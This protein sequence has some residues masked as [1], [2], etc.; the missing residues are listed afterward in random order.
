[1]PERERNVSS[2]PSVSASRQCRRKTPR[3]LV[4]VS[5]AVEKAT[6]GDVF[7]RGQA[8]RAP[9]VPGPRSSARTRPVA[10]FEGNTGPV[11]C[12][13]AWARM[14]PGS[15]RRIVSDAEKRHQ[16]RWTSSRKIQGRRHELLNVDKSVA[17]GGGQVKGVS[18]DWHSLRRGRGRARL[19]HRR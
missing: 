2:S 9:Y 12:A 17:S 11:H 7:G 14:R 3:D 13:D 16:T 8:V 19:C 1:M 4:L 10:A 6:P 15:R 18:Q 5:P